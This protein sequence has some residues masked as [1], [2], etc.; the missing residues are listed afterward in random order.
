MF[1]ML[2][3][4]GMRIPAL[5]GLGYPLGA[6]VALGIASA[7]DLARREAGGVEGK[8]VLRR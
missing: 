5:Y 1:W 4:A 7:L 2:V 3:S 6:V 8:G